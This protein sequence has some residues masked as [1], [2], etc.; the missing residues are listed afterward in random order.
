MTPEPFTNA[1]LLADWHRRVRESQF[2]HYNAAKPLGRTNYLLGVPVTILSTFVGTSLFA[3]LEAH[4]TAN[5]RLAIG[6]VSVT[7]A[8]LAS[9]QTFLRFSERA[10]KHRAVAARYGSLRRDIEALQAGGAPY[11]QAKLD[12]LKEK[13]NSISEEAPE[14]SERVWRST[15]AILRER[16]KT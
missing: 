16:L 2:A 6:F 3:T 15:E 7:A 1:E 5:F 12:S 8:I 14:I 11:D 13:L 9:M 4:A 10:E